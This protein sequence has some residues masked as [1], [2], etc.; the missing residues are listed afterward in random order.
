MTLH[1]EKGT[2][3]VIP[4]MNKPNL[5]IR[6]DLQP[7][8]IYSRSGDI[9][10]DDDLE[11]ISLH[12]PDTPP[13]SQVQ[14]R[15]INNKSMFVMIGTIKFPLNL[16]IALSVVLA[17]LSSGAIFIHE[18]YSDNE[19]VGTYGGIFFGYVKW[20][21]IYGWTNIGII[22]I[23]FWLFSISKCTDMK[24]ET[25]KRNILCLGYL[26]QFSWYIVGAILYFVE[27]NNSCSTGDVLYDFGLALFIC[28]TVVLGSIFLQDRRV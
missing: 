4:H 19:C 24:F 27:V 14:H 8:Y 7:E 1:P 23:M 16:F 10:H 15:E 2:F 18:R 25:L 22:G 26:F 5:H 11:E 28:Q 17:I 21:Y 20:L 3:A 13:M 12:T 9:I 6:V